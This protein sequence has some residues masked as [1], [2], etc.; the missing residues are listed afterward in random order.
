MTDEN[1]GE[2]RILDLLAR[3]GAA[4]SRTSAM[5][6]RKVRPAMLRKP[7][8]TYWLEQSF[9]MITPTQEEPVTFQVTVNELWTGRGTNDVVGTFIADTVPLQR[10]EVRQQ[11]RALSRTFAPSALADFELRAN[12]ELASPASF[13]DDLLECRYSVEVAADEVLQD[14]LRKTWEARAQAEADHHRKHRE[15]E[16]LE[17]LRD[18]WLAFLRDLESDPLGLLA[19]QLADNP[20]QLAEVITRRTSDRE[21]LEQELRKICEKTSET[22]RNMGVFDFVMETDGALRTL[23]RYLGIDRPDADPH[24]GNGVDPAA[25]STNGDSPPS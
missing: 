12:E 19:V 20:A 10:R 23:I 13:W 4:L 8:P 3:L 5:L 11:L 16:N 15:L 22:Y 18:R 2:R 24:E 9:F 14:H 6:L 21:R 25:P 1:S 17:P 7:P